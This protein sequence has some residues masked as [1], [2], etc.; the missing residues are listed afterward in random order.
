M[1]IYELDQIALVV[2]IN[3]LLPGLRTRSISVPSSCSCSS[4]S[5]ACFASSSSS[6]SSTFSFLRVQVRVRVLSKFI[7]FFSSSENKM[8]DLF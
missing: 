5:S 8:I 2:E 3:N 6:L 1:V 4:S 7:K